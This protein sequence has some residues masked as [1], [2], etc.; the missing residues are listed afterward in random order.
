MHAMKAETAGPLAFLFQDDGAIPNNPLLPFLLYPKAV[1]L[2][3]R[4]DPAEAFEQTFAANGWG[5]N[6]WRNGIYPFPHYHSMIHEAMGIARGKARVRFGG[7]SGEEIDL[8]AGDVAVLPAGTGH[9]RIW[10]SYDLIVV[11]AYPSS[12]RY[13]LCR[14]S[15]VEHARAVKTIPLVPHPESDPVYGAHG[16]LLALWAR[17]A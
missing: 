8:A 16:P 3:G 13:N 15:R 5:D 17:T 14:G 1:D 10:A 11:G 2:R 4:I 6:M 7:T 9:E 12:G